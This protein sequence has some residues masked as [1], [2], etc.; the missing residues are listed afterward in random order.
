MSDG[1][2]RSLPMRRHWKDLA[3]RAAKAAFSP[4]QVAEGLPYALKK[5]VLGGPVDE[6]RD[7]MG[8]AT[9]FPH[10][11]V[12]QL[13]LLRQSHHGSAAASH[14]ID[15]AVEAAANGLVGDSGTEAALKNAYEG[16]ARDALRG[17]EEHYQREAPSRSAKYVRERLDAARQQLD[18]G[19]L[20]R[21]LLSLQKLPSQ[22]SINLPRQSG[23]DEGPP[24]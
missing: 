21:E 10:L 6:S 16:I 17:I 20:A 24:L 11:M 18:S 4:N 13:E 5:D 9:L 1:P 2:H 8:G 15:C 22:R 12:E 3:E 19:E 7:I 23:I 14:L